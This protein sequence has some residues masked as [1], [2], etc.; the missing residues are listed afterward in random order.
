M[1]EIIQKTLP[2]QSMMINYEV[3]IDNEKMNKKIID[4][5]DKSGDRQKRESNVKAD[6]TDWDMR[7]KPGFKE[8]IKIT[9]KVVVDVQKKHFNVNTKLILDDVWGT[10]YK[11]NEETIEHDHYPAAWSFV[12]YPN[13]TK[14][15]P[16]LTFREANVERTIVKGLLMF[17]LGNVRHSVQKKEY[18]GYRYCVAG[19][20][21]DLK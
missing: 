16:G 8:L 10:K 3:M 5:I 11:S 9:D 18:E 4:Q 1:Y 14:G 19:N 7:K 2:M 13:A 6:M 21:K 12:Y 17:F 15:A 20:Y